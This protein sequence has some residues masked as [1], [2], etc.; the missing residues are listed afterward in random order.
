MSFKLRE[1]ADVFW[2]LEWMV[3]NADRISPEWMEAV[4]RAEDE[5]QRLLEHCMHQRDELAGRGGRMSDFEYCTDEHLDGL[6]RD[7]LKSEVRW[8]HGRALEMEAE[9]AKLLELLR[10]MYA[11]IE[12]LCSMVENSPGCSMCPTNQDEEKPCAAADVYCRMRELGVEP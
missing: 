12:A 8:W 3:R 9:N 7:A 10:D 1:T 4:N 6:S 2:A 5:Y 11:C